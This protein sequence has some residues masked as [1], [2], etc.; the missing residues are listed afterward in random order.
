MLFRSD[1]VVLG[2]SY[3][4]LT[5]LDPARAAQVSPQADETDSKRPFGSSQNAS[6]QLLG[7]YTQRL[8]EETSRQQAAYPIR[9]HY[10]R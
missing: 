5:Y 4:L 3:R 1:V 2:A 10:S 7:L 9:I 6:R 8:S